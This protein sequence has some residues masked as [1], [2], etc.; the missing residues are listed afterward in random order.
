MD[1]TNID[2]SN[3]SDDLGFRYGR[4]DAPVKLY[5]YLNVECPFSRIY[6]QTNTALINEFVDAGKVQYIV[7][8]VDRPT[9]HL[10]KGNVMHRY[11]TYDDPENAFEQ[12][13]TMF[14]TRQEWTK[15]DED[16]VA[17]HAE[18]VLGYT[19]QDNDAV[20][21]AIKE[22]AVQVG[23]KTVPTAYV[24]GEAFDEHEDNNTVR[25]WINAAYATA[26][27]EEAFDFGA[28][29]LNLDAVTDKR[30]IKYGSDDAPVKITEYINFRCRGSK[31]F[32][33]AISDKLEQLADAG[34]V[35]RII[36]HVDID[37]AGLYKGEVINRFVD[38]KDQ[39]RAYKQFKEIFARHG[40]WS[41]YDFGGIV[42]VAIETFSYS[43][44]GNKI[45]T[46]VVKEEFKNLGAVATPTIVANGDKAFVGP[47][48]AQELDDYLATIIEE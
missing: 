1:A 46:E 17:K 40:E 35:Q 16:G 12:L 33:D 11:L 39:D 25:D 45:Q 4:P 9:G 2:F 5:A 15:L 19:V 27:A 7:K 20:Q 23:A 18:E 42:D 48:A 24:F 8:P 38:Y 28:D 32:E 43:Y 21:E 10:R 44:Q 26:T 30:A 31:R 29:K 13:T 14:A 37:A 6:E 36:K 41:A 3:V 22:E 34:K 47:N